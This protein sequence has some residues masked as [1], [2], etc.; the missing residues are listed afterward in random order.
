[1]RTITV[2]TASADRTGRFQGVLKVGAFPDGSPVEI[3]VIIVRGQEDGPV[4]WMHGCVHGN[5]YCGTYSIHE[6]TRS[7]DPASLKGAVVA[8]P[9]LNL[10]A[11]RSRQRSSPFE[12]FNNTDMNR[13]FPGNPNGGMTEQMA[14]VVFEELK[15]TATHFIDFHTAY[16]ADTRWAL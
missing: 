11:F 10:A 2:G 14:Y 3:P 6:F 15:K 9:I 12:I 13:C 4:V 5:E 8:L 7:L 1:M 16:T